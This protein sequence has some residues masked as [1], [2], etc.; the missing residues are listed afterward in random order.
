MGRTSETTA[1]ALFAAS[2]CFGP[3][4]ERRD[5]RHSAAVMADLVRL[6]FMPDHLQKERT[7]FNW[8]A[9][10][11][12]ERAG[13][14]RSSAKARAGICLSRSGAGSEREDG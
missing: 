9:R 4:G 13:S 2:V 11:C 6:I 3:R 14:I 1:R 5:E 7:I 8:A 10:P 12:P